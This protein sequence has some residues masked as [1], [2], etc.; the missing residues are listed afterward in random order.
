M[1]TATDNRWASGGLR[2]TSPGYKREMTRYLCVHASHRRDGK[3]VPVDLTDGVRLERSLVPRPAVYLAVTE[4]LVNETLSMRGPSADRRIRIEQ[5]ISGEVQPA[6]LP[7]VLVSERSS[8]RTR[9][10]YEWDDLR[11]DASLLDRLAEGPAGNQPGGDPND[12]VILLEDG[13]RDNGG[14]AGVLTRT[15]PR[16]RVIP[17]GIFDLHELAARIAIAGSD[18][19]AVIDAIRTA[20]H[21]TVG[22][23]IADA[24]WRVVVPCSAV[25][26]DER[27]HDVLFTG[28]AGREPAVIYGTT[29]SGLDLSV[30]ETAPGDVFPSAELARVERGA[31]M[32]VAAEVLI[33]TAVLLCAWVSGALALAA[34]EQA[35]WLG[36]SLLLAAAAVA[37]A[38]MPWF[39]SREPDANMNDVFDVRRVYA[40]R[41]SLIAWAAAISVVLFGAALIIGIAP[42]LAIRHRAHHEHVGL[43]RYDGQPRH[44]VDRGRR[45]E[46]GVGRA[47]L[48]RGP[49]VR[50]RGRRRNRASTPLGSRERG[51]DG[52]DRPTAGHAAGRPVPHRRGR[53]AGGRAPG[54]HADD[55][56]D[57][58]L[59]DRDDPSADR[60]HVD[61]WLDEH[62]ERERFGR[63]AAHHHYPLGRPNA[64]SAR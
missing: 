54:L 10:R 21:A 33:G 27:P 4:E 5:Y 20:P 35:T 26:S 37:F 12:D 32:L 60:E 25:E 36:A 23:V 59:H 9:G 47:V 58:G 44:R 39:V 46:R 7:V 45:R 31:T 61:E 50:E 43:L 1:P 57:A 3:R 29:A 49:V 6:N 13:G 42:V 64:V 63:H 55:D 30:E 11:R 28:L 48:D 17:Q 15:R 22:E 18:E 34:R 52:R 53:S 16:V 62:L 8:E 41:I 51:W 56:A 38:A 2:R 14:N 40:S 19:E 24:P